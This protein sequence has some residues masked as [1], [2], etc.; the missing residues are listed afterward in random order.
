MNGRAN[1]VVSPSS[2]GWFVG[3]IVLAAVGGGVMVIGAFIG[4]IAEIT[5][6][7]DKSGT[8]TS[9]E[10]TGWTMAGVGAIGLVAG[11]VALA[12]N[13]HSGVEMHGDGAVPAPQH[14]AT[15]REAPAFAGAVPRA[16]AVPI[17]SGSF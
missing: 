5:A 1:L 17:L 6:T 15:W 3:G 13:S 9:I 16:V 2:S 4:L 7:V 14:A 8:S 10:S 12:S 11:I